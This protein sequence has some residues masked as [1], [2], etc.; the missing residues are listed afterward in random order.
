MTLSSIVDKM[1][2]VVL[3]EHSWVLDHIAKDSAIISSLKNEISRHLLSSSTD[4]FFFRYKKSKIMTYAG[5]QISGPSFKRL[6]ST[7]Q[8]NYIKKYKKL[9]LL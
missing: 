6:L 3:K 8:N 4:F 2:I 7:E 9:N 1:Y 5:I